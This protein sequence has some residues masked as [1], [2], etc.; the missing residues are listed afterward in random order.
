MDTR[1]LT[2]HPLAGA[3]RV[4]AVPGKQA[5]APAHNP[6]RKS[7]RGSTGRAP[8]YI[9]VSST[10]D[11]TPP[12]KGN[13]RNPG[14][15]T[16]RLNNVIATNSKN[17]S[18]SDTVIIA[19]PSA[20]IVDQPQTSADNT[21]RTETNHGL[22]TTPT[23][24][25]RRT[26]GP[27]WA[28]METITLEKFLNVAGITREDQLT[29]AHMQ[30]HGITHWTFFRSSNEEDLIALG[31]PIGVARLLCKGVPRLEAHA[32]KLI[33]NQHRD[34]ILAGFNNF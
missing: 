28:D 33:A 21:A 1:Y 18:S 34:E 20:V 15:K 26:L 24:T 29:R 23:G 14:S 19:E 12:A 27:A 5:K 16:R 31:F 3:R 6:K 25:V 22:A 9:E 7:A 4:L 13:A 32:D 2:W 10:N 8:A 17:G 11:P 30:V